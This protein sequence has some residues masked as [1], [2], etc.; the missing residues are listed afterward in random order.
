MSNQS[1]KCPNCGISIPLADVLTHDIKHQLKGEMEKEVRQKEKELAEKEKSLLEGQKNI[2]AQVAE[3]LEKGKIEM[4]KIAQQKAAEKNEFEFKNLQTE[5]EEKNKR[6][7]EMQTQ[8]LELRKQ[9]R[10]LEEKEKMMQLEL[11][12]QLDEEREKIAETAKKDASEETRMKILEKDKQL[13][14][15]RKTIEDL[16]RKSEQGSMQIQGDTQEESVK[17]L[18]QRAFPLDIIEDVPT[19]I[20]GADLIQTVHSGFGQKTGIILWESKNTKTW[21]NDWIKK[22]KDDQGIVKADVCI[23]ITKTLPDEIKNF[24]V[25]DGVWVVAYPFALPLVNTLRFH[26]N[27]LDQLKQSQVGKGE[28]MEYLYNYLSGNEF[29]NRIENIVNAFGSLKNELERE[30]RAMER[31]WSR[32]AKEIDR[33]MNNTSGMYGDL[34]GI[35]GASLPTIQSLELPEGEL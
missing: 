28:K 27:E 8:E 11:T 5:V 24:G 21:S 2:D 18:L 9:K 14:Q 19:G 17:E 29:K 32:R 30:K 22:L 31:I 3:R 34:Q 20:K 12:R 26:L 7:Q 4:W 35:I 16:K 1:I 13:D 25:K 15:M 23:L 33:V 6:L 10:E